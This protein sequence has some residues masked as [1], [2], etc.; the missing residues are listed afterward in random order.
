MLRVSPLDGD[1]ET[2]RLHVEGRLAGPPALEVFCKE[3]AQAEASGRRVMVELSG[4][5]FADDDA[6]AVLVGALARGVELCGSSAWLVSR[7]EAT[8]A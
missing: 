2:Y 7:L 3:L 1:P 8:R 5:R 6:V 4:L